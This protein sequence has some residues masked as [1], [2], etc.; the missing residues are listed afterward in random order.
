[1][2]MNYPI[3]ENQNIAVRTIQSRIKKGVALLD[4]TIPNWADMI[5]PA[6]LNISNASDCVIG[7]ITAAL[8]G[9]PYRPVDVLNHNGSRTATKAWNE[10]F[11]FNHSRPDGIPQTRNPRKRTVFQIMSACWKYH[12]KQRQ[13]AEHRLKL[14]HNFLDSQQ[15]K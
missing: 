6:R 4:S 13:T 11:G 1:M 12:V 7:Q 3:A 10:K 14:V 2:I 5:D 15:A 9:S 8:N